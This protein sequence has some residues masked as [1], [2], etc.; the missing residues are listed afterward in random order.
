[1]PVVLAVL[2]AEKRTA[3]EDQA[4]LGPDRPRRGMP[5][6]RANV[7][8]AAIPA[9]TS[10]ATRIATRVGIHAPDRMATVSAS[11]VKLSSFAS[12]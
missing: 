5:S 9:A 10:G 2:T 11:Y 3:G 8:K 4:V 6:W 7:A 12:M 1:L